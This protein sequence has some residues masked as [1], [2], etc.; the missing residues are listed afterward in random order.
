[1]VRLKGAIFVKYARQGLAPT[2]K[3]GVVIDNLLAHKRHEVHTI[4]EAAGA[5]LHDLPP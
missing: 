2:L 4:I 3:P 1:M 5:T